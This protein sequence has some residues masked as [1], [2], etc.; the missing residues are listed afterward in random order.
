M[1]SPVA[2]HYVHRLKLYAPVGLRM[3]ISVGLVACSY[4]QI[5]IQ[6]LRVYPMI[7]GNTRPQL[8]PLKFMHS[9]TY[10]IYKNYSRIAEFHNYENILHN[11][12]TGSS[13]IERVE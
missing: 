7:P 4:F 12:T 9:R 8:V 5:F 1:A 2:S 3:H 13:H 11:I 6:S 10:A